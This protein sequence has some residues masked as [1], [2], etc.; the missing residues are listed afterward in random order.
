MTPSILMTQPCGSCG[1]SQTNEDKALVTH[2][3]SVLSYAFFP[4]PLPFSSIN[5]ECVE[6]NQ[7]LLSVVNIVLRSISTSARTSMLSTLI[8]KITLI[9]FLR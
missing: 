4:P 7:I 9:F 8:N 5:N 3:G 1:E 6:N 2:T